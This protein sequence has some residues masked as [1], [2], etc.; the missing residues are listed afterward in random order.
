[1]LTILEKADLLQNA[2]IFCEIRTQSLARVAAIAQEVH[3]EARHRLFAVDE[4]P[5]A[6]FVC[7]EGE[8]TLTRVGVE[9]RRLSTLQTV[10]SL[11][12]LANQ[13]QTETAVAT[14]AVRAL[15]ISQQDLFDA[16]AEDFSITRGILRALADKAAAR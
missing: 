1:M 5:D 14:Q 9:E 16:M 4:A 15:R 11:T 10:G 2:E 6:M 8:V 12:L 3:F 7:L 13:T